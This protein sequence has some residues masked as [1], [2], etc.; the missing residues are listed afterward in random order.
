M[1]EQRT[2]QTALQANLQKTNHELEYSQNPMMKEGSSVDIR[3]MKYFISVAETLSFTKAAK[4]HYISQTA[5]SQQIASMEEEL[6]F[7]LFART[8][9]RVAL[10]ASGCSLL[11]D[12]KGIVDRYERAVQ[13]AK[14]LR[15]NAPH[16][17]LVA[18]TD[19]TEREFLADIIEEYQKMN[20]DNHNAIDVKK[21]GFMD[22]NT[23]MMNDLYDAVIAPSQ[24]FRDIKDIETLRLCSAELLLGV[25]KNHPKAK[26]F[27][28]DASEIAGEKILMS[29]RDIGPEMVD[30]ALEACRLDGYEPNFVECDKILSFD[31]YML[32]VEM[33]K[34]VAFLPDSPRLPRSS[35]IAYLKIMN[36]V[37]RYNIDLAWKKDRTNPI[38]QTFIA[39]ACRV[40]QSRC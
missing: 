29:A 38:L 1:K 17:I 19:E 4:Q 2:S 9:N 32:L 40:Q 14:N 21:I 30:Y 6:G 13:K 33:D 11:E 5:M 22:L 27:T 12:V 31:A 16:S 7:M 36:S 3:K 39:A 37:H 26:Q 20:P 18:F 34:G 10:T 35:R 25:S 15:D 23:G 8:R 28:I 24:L